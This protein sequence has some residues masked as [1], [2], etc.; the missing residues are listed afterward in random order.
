MEQRTNTLIGGQNLLGFQ[1]FAEIV[2][3]NDS[4]RMGGHMEQFFG[5]TILFFPPLF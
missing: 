5:K 2:E 4:L 1:E 3:N